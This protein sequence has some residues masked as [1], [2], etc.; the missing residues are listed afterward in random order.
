MDG[1]KYIGDNDI[2]KGMAFMLEGNYL[3]GDNR[4]PKYGYFE[5]KVSKA[6]LK[7]GEFE[8]VKMD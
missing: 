2:L 8:A 5:I 1:Y 3:I 4:T 7:S 6:A